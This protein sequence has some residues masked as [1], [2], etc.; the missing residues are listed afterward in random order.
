LRSG[1]DALKAALGLGEMAPVS[2]DERE[3]DDDNNSM[4]E[5]LTDQVALRAL[6][7]LI[8]AEGTIGY[9][10]KRNLGL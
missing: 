9:E 2:R 4:M 3:L 7:P 10:P 6:R 8:E 5:C 1:T